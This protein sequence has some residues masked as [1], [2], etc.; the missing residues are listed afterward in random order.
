M[1]LKGTEFQIRVWKAIK[2]IPKGKTKTYKELASII[3]RPKAARAT[4]NA[5][6]KNPYPIKIPCHRVIR[7]DGNIG[8]YSGK[9]GVNSKMILLKKEGVLFNEFDKVIT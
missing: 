8:G 5:C 2:N 7:S 6:V 3:G 9:G 1:D 4:A